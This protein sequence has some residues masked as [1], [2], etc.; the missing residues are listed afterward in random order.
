[1]KVVKIIKQNLEDIQIIK[2]NLQTIIKQ[3]L[4]DIY[5]RFWILGYVFKCEDYQTEPGRY[6]F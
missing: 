3:N 2:N 4:D 1:M 6:L 5:F